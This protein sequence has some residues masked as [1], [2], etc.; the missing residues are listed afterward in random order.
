MKKLKSTGFWLFALTVIAAL[1][2][3]VDVSAAMTAT[4]VVV[5]GVDE[6]G[7]HITNAPLDTTITKD[8][9]PSLIL[10]DIDDRIT[11]ISPYRNPIDQ[12][13]RLA[14]RQMTAHG[15][16]YKHYSID[17]AP[18]SATVSATYNE[19]GSSA[20]AYISV[21]NPDLFN[22]TDTVTVVG[23]KGYDAAG[24]TVTTQDL[25]LYIAG[26]NTD[27]PQKL[28]VV[29]INGKYVSSKI[30]V[31]TIPS[32]TALKI[33]AT[34]A[35][36]GDIRSYTNAS[37]P[38][39]IT[40]YCQI[41]KAEVGESTIQKMSLK[42]VDWSLDDQIEIAVNKMRVGIEKSSLVGIKGK[43]FVPNKNAYVYTTGGILWDIEKEFEMPSLPTNADLI[44]FAQYV[45]SGQSG[46][47]RKILLMGS[48][49]GAA[50]SKIGSVQKQLESKNTEIHWGLTW[51]MITTNEGTFA[52]LPYDVLNEM[53]RSDEAIVIDPDY[54]DKWTLVPF[55]SKD[56]DLKASGIYDGD[57][58]VSTEISSICLRYKNAHCKA[59]LKTTVSV[60][61][62]T[63]TDS[64]ETVEIGDT[65][66]FA[67]K[68]TIAPAN[69]TNKTITY[70]SSDLTVATIDA[71][72]VVTAIAEGEA[73]VSARTNDGNFTV[74]AVI[75][76][77][78]AS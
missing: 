4:A 10:P 34:A 65:W 42:E 77:P 21:D 47:N 5:D 1:F 38:T 2:G 51:N 35:I 28:Y 25:M 11:K 50:I 71:D 22:E 62:I 32:G 59:K 37:L 33:A 52:A 44:D 27:S 64:A 75:T 58:N 6:V 31:P 67:S 9:S 3:V 57:V 69:A 60:T 45:F 53:G 68:L 72:G 8:E 41:Y 15:M 43:T 40:G 76:V 30:T 70:V 17:T 39:P 23:V 26:K 56:L 48:E 61:G 46:S 74:I 18:T 66:D 36:E 63:T 24:T 78:A 13:A 55:G 54:I 20:Y 16:E 49:F 29:A 7:K 14:G 12:I 73:V 19:S